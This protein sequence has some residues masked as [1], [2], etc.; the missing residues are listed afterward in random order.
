MF[1]PN[2]M[3]KTKQ[4]EKSVQEYYEIAKVDFATEIGNETRDLIYVKDIST[5]LKTLVDNRGLEESS[6]VFRV[7]MDGGNI[8]TFSNFVFNFVAIMLLQV[9]DSSK[10]ALIFLILVM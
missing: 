7:S 10:L 1:E 8:N 9:A 4:K 6:I 5:L 2:L 3:D